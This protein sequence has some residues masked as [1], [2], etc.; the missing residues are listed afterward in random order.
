MRQPPQPTPI[1]HA[2]TVRF[3]GLANRVTTPVTVSEAFDPALAPNPPPVQLDTVALWDTGAT[4]SVVTESTARQL[5]LVATGTTNVN[6]AGGSSVHNRYVVNLVLPNK[7]SVVGVVVSECPD[8]AGAFG[9]IIGMDI[10]S[11]GDFS[12]TGASGQTVMS[13][14]WPSMET[15]DYVVEAERVKGLSAVERNKG[16]NDL[17]YCGSGKKFKYCH[18]KG[19]T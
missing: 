10:I 16:R 9:V 18:G 12:I 17:C 8:V 3:N 1:F 7:V 13:F 19:T 5:G 4:H 6:H 15:V 14:R 11:A 2:F